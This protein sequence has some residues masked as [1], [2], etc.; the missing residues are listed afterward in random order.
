MTGHI[1]SLNTDRKSG[2]ELEL[3]VHS[4]MKSANSGTNFP[5]GG[6]LRLFAMFVGASLALT[7]SATRGQAA[8]LVKYRVTPESTDSSIHRFND[9]HYVV[10]ERTTTSAAPLLVFMPGTGGMPERTS[11]F[12]D[13]A[14]HMGYRVIGLEY[15]DTPAVAQ[16]CPKNRDPKCSE[17][18]RQKRIYGDDVTDVIDDRPSE[19][20]VNRLTRLLTT[21]YHD[22]PTE[23]W[24]DYLEN[25][26][27]KWGKIAVSGL[28]QGAGMAAYIAQKTLVAR[29]I[30]FSSPW[31]NY[32]PRQT[33]APWIV[34]GHGE[35]PADRWFAAYHEKEPT[36]AAIARAYA[37]LGIPSSQIRVFTLEPAPTPA[38]L[39]DW[40]F[41]M[42]SVR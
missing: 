40:R 9:P 17:H 20:V 32:G 10:F 11:A 23:G 39:E 28:S 13:L 38:Y 33:L 25:G 36:A 21:L 3:I 18:F 24:A 42:G 1:D 30:L 6:G 19:S 2:P 4:A 8:A 35:T 27:P 29:V 34:T 12:A 26:Q 15:T 37:A 14:A 5:R 16:L 22:H 41:L 7:P 31:D